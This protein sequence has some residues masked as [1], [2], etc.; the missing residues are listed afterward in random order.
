MFTKATLPLTVV[1]GLIALGW[2]SFFSVI[3]S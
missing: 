1:I 3:L 2:L